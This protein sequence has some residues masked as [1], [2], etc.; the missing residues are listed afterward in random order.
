MGGRCAEELI[1]QELTTGAGDDIQK[2][3]DLARKIV[4]E[5]GMSDLGPL[6]FGHEA[7]EVFLGR[8]FGHRQE[9]SEQTALEID[10]E[11]KK[12]VNRNYLRAKEILKGRLENLHQLAHHLLER[13]TLDGP[14]I[15]KIIKGETLDPMKKYIPPASPLAVESSEKEKA[16]RIKGMPPLPHPSKA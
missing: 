14:E 6:S 13:E 10:Q 5:W 3:T 16:P 8:D 15:D 9:Y 2:A 1:F 4:C 7:A 11:I 12:I